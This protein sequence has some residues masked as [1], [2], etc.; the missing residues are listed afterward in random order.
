MDDVIKTMAKA[1]TLH[2][3]KNKSLKKQWRDID[4]Q[5]QLSEKEL[6]KHNLDTVGGFI[7]EFE[8]LKARISQIEHYSGAAKNRM[9]EHISENNKVIEK[10]L[11]KLNK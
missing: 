5:L 11:K 10:I 7:S 6:F 9:E 1:M 8:N 3:T 2:Q 4:L